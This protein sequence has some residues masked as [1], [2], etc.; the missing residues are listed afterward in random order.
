M[1]PKNALREQ[2][3]Q[4]RRS[5][6]A[7][8]R[9][10]KDQQIQDALESMDAFKKA[11]TILFYVSNGEEVNTHRL[12]QKYLKEKSIVIPRTLKKENGLALCRLTAWEALEPSHFGILEVPS[13]D[14]NYVHESEL[15][16]A[17]I[18]G[19]AFDQNGH[20]LGYGGGYYDRFLKQLKKI[21]SI[22]LSYHCQ[23]IEA[24]PIEPHDVQVD[25][26]VTE[27]K[28]YSIKH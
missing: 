18:P 17:I 10:A 2:F 1:E 12:I 3:R 4:K 25:W 13:H 27:Q 8:E 26:I 16:L 15:D 5:L 19:I 21:K 22:G 28:I 14:T 24:L 20:R 9:K 23:I 7:D 6:S 11:K